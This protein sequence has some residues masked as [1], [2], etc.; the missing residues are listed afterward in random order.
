MEFVIADITG[1]IEGAHSGKG[2][3]TQFLGH[4]E[5]CAGLIHIIDGIYY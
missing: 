2:L 1:L 3:G 5:R 4:V